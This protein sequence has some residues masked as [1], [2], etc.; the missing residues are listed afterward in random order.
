[1]KL[2]KISVQ[3]LLNYCNMKKLCFLF[4]AFL[5][6]FNCFS[7]DLNAR[8]K[9]LSPK[10]QSNNK[11]ALDVLELAIRE[12]LNNRKWLTDPVKPAERID[13][14]FVINIVEWDGS[15]VF[16]AEAQIVS[17]R[18]IFGSSYSSQLL[19]VNDR[20]FDFNYSE[21]ESLE[22]N[23][24]AFTSNLTSMLAFY[25]NVIAGLDYD[26][27]SSMGGSPYYA[28]AQTIVNSAQNADFTGW[29]AFDN[30]KNRYWIAEN[31]NSA[32]YSPLREIL[33]N[34]HRK[35]LD[36]MYNNPNDGRKAIADI[37]PALATL[38]KQKQGTILT[39]IFFSAKADE[40]VG[41]FA[42]ADPQVKI[43]I[44]NLLSDVDPSNI[45]K[46]EE[47]KKGN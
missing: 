21:G 14:T 11:R 23:D 30:L 33:Y 45:S 22:F 9:I 10:I 36:V 41:I 39:Q 25:A 7:Q 38:D 47:L 37:L 6:S 29:K 15:K 18:P 35:G 28:K 17:T 13:C 31:L 32:S 19:S 43:K 46:Y 5:I 40:I 12:F 2:P 20:N 8:V 3:R 27:F 24:Q 34:Y 42:K 26:S 1:M 4:L 44:Y 16:K